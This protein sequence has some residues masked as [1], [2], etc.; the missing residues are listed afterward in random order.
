MK[1]M[2]ETDHVTLSLSILNKSRDDTDSFK[3]SI[4]KSLLEENFEG[5]N[6]SGDE[7]L[8][9]ST[10][11]ADDIDSPNY[12]PKEKGSFQGNRRD[13]LF[14]AIEEVDV[15]YETTIRHTQQNKLDDNARREEANK[16]N[17]N[18][19]I[20]IQRHT[21]SE[22]YDPNKR[23]I[24]D[25]NDEHSQVLKPIIKNVK[26]RQLSHQTVDIKA[27]REKLQQRNANKSFGDSTRFDAEGHK[28]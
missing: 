18:D 17:S 23:S 8:Y 15:D 26:N 6:Q 25:S 5:Y 13:M 16:I 21:S 24:N 22:P 12:K 20:Q 11:S 9:K 14:N 3:H 4:K 27:F 7:H 10:C 2:I 19:S 28:I 1:G